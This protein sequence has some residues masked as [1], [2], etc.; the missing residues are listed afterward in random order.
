MVAVTET[1][2]FARRKTEKPKANSCKVCRA[3]DWSRQRIQANMDAESRISGLYFDP[4]GESTVYGFLH[5]QLISMNELTIIT[6]Q[7]EFGTQI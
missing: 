5:G 3:A 1:R 4:F 6:A 7:R 2:G